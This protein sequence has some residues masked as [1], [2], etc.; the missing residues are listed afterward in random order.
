LGFHL[1]G[2]ADELLSLRLIGQLARQRVR[3]PLDLGRWRER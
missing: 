3:Y 1:L 2:N